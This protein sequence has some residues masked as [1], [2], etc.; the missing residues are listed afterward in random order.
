[1]TRRTRAQHKTDDY[2]FP[3]RVKFVVPDG[4]LLAISDTFGDRCR[5]WLVAELGPDQWAWHSAGM[6][7]HRQASALYFRTPAAAQRFV[8][9]FPE[10]A[11]ADGTGAAG[12]TAPGLTRRS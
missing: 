12:H 11:L 4:G 3:V 9:A 7:L 1:M 8:E 10:F 2:R 5:A 6:S